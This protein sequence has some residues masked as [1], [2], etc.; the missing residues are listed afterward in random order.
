MTVS[1]FVSYLEILNI[2]HINWR[3]TNNIVPIPIIANNPMQNAAFICNKIKEKYFSWSMKYS[4]VNCIRCAWDVF[5]GK[6]TLDVINKNSAVIGVNTLQ[7]PNTKES[8]SY[9]FIFYNI[10]KYYFKHIY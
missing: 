10:S 5:I 6:T 4:V 3:Y 2:P 1:I 7:M 9:N 8:N